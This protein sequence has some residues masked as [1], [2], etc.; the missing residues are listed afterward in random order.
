MIFTVLG[1]KVTIRREKRLN[2]RD[3]IGYARMCMEN[4]A[5][6]TAILREEVKKMQ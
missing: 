4:K 2:P 1:Y 3:C 5:R 6:T